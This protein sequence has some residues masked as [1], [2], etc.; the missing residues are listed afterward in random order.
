[1]NRRIRKKKNNPYIQLKKL[2]A[3]EIAL[4][5][6]DMDDE[7]FDFQLTCQFFNKVCEILPNE[8]SAILLPDYMSMKELDK[9]TIKKFINKAQEIVDRM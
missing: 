8:T 5:T 7:N 2:K 6:F 1:M 4:F 3:S 9:E